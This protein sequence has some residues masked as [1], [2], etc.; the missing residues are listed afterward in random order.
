MLTG[1]GFPKN[2]GNS[3]RQDGPIKDAIVIVGCGTNSDSFS[4]RAYGKAEKLTCHAIKRG[5][6][7]CR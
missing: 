4:N 2:F 1:S 3:S 5:V 6:A 7:F